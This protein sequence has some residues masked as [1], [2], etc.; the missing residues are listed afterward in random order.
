MLAVAV[1]AKAALHMPVA[2]AG[3]RTFQQGEEDV[4]DGILLQH[5]AAAG[6][7]TDVAAVV[8]A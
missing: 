2:A 1:P 3:L 5:R 7:M 6:L 4:Q 8:A